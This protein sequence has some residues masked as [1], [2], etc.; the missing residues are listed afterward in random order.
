M[1]LAT[2]MVARA[3]DFSAPAPSGQTLYF[4]IRGSAVAVVN[5]EWDY[6]IMPA[7]TLVL[8]AQV[9]RDGTTY[10]VTTIGQSAFESCSNI[11]RV[12]VPE[13][14]TTIEGFAF[15]RCAALD[16]IEL[17]ST[18]TEIR[19]QVFNYTAYAS[20]PANRD[21][22]GLLY[23]GQYLIGGSANAE[24][25]VAEGTLGIA[26][27]A[28]YY[29]QNLTQ[30]EFPATL[31]FVSD[32]AFSDCTALDTVRMLCTTPPSAAVN[33]FLQTPQFTLAVPC[34]TGAAYAAAAVW[35]AFD[36][37]EDC[38]GPVQGIGDAVA[39]TMT[40]TLAADGIYVGGATGRSVCVSDMAGRIVSR[41]PK[42]TD[43]QY[44]PLPCSG[45]YILVIEG[46]KP[47][48]IVYR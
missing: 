13:G 19:S 26:A 30:I 7:G 16:T 15:Y 9:E 42:A 14:V 37:V 35:N 39:T 36:I 27:M 40:T 44:L 4:E 43:T 38:D 29:Q 2:A 11:T 12:V 45:L 3:F 46:E 1:L 23:V 17:P 47:Q 34:N 28:F 31:R 5:P 33:A 25:V 18:L 22:Q 20:N 48:K 24:V 32:Q 10:P 41:V 21:S 8:P 6:Y